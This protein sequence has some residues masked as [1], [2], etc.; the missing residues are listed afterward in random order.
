MVEVIQTGD[1]KKVDESSW[2]NLRFD[3]L[4]VEKLLELARMQRTGSI[5]DFTRLMATLIKNEGQT[6]VEEKKE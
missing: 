4:P 1:G 5:Q 6:V 3:N 2:A